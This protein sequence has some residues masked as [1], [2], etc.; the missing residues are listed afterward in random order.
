MPA[1][2]VDAKGINLHLKSGTT[3]LHIL[4]DV[5]LTL[6]P[7][8]VKTTWT[9]DNIVVSST[10]PVMVGQILVS[11]AYVDGP[12]LGDPS[13]TVFPPIEQFRSEYVFLAPDGWTQSWVVISAPVGGKVT[14]DGAAPNGCIVEPA[15]TIES[16]TYET[17][18]CAVKA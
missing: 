8:E 9:Q 2:V 12:L 14:V 4:K 17:R 5:D 15:G 13:L 10:K 1:P 3:S 7:G 18:R 16:V 11:N 6:Q